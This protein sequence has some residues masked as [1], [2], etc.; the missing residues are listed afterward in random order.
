MSA[1]AQSIEKT[2]CYKNEFNGKSGNFN[3]VYNPLIILNVDSNLNDI[4]DT[5][6]NKINGLLI[7]KESVDEICGVY[8]VENQN[9]I[10]ISQNVLLTTTINNNGTYNIYWSVN[11]FKVQ[12]K[13]GDNKSISVG[14]FGI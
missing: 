5:T 11:Q 4:I 1:P 10:V 3:I 13:V 14:F 9:I 8:R 12:N 7:L 6:V 2:E